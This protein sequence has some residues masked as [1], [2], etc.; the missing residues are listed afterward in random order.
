[1]YSR[2]GKNAFDSR[3]DCRGN[4]A[5]WH[6]DLRSV[7]L[8]FVPGGPDRLRNRARERVE[9]RRLQAAYAGHRIHRRHFTAGHAVGRIRRPVVFRFLS[10]VLLNRAR[11]KR[12][13]F[14]EPVSGSGVRSQA[15]DTEWLALRPR[16]KDEA[17]ANSAASLCE[18]WVFAGTHA[19]RS[20][21][22]P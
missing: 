10:A 6:A 20:I 21:S 9:R 18:L 17:P 19:K 8:G 22:F 11:A 13:R 15:L 14:L 4:F 16:F 5:V 7:A 2:A 1:M 3:R 12:A